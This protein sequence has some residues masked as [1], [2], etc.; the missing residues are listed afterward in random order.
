MLEG[1]HEAGVDVDVGIYLNGRDLIAPVH[2]QPAD[3]CRGYAF[4][5]T[6]HNSACNH[7]VSHIQAFKSVAAPYMIR[8]TIRIEDAKAPGNSGRLSVTKVRTKTRTR[9]GK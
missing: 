5:K 3:G 8:V 7:D 2:E 6:A 4:P 9:T 1:A